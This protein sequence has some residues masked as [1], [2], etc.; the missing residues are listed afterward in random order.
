MNIVIITKNKID[1]IMIL[2]NEYY[3]N[4]KMIKIDKIMILNN[5]YCDNHK[6]NQN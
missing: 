2:N 4:H 6:N 3:D 5:E 1:K